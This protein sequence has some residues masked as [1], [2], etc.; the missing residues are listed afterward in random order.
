L[1]RVLVAS[2]SFG[3]G[4]PRKALEELLR[5]H[6]LNPVFSSIEQAGESI[7][8]CEGII[9]GTEQAGAALFDRSKALKAIIKYGVGIDNIDAR[10]AEQRGIKVLSLPEINSATV[11]EM[12][13]SLMLACARKIVEGNRALRNKNTDRPVG[14]PVR[15]KTLG[16]L[17]TGAIGMALV[18]MVSGLEMN[19]LAHDIKPNPEL[20]NLGGRYL[21]LEKLLED[22]DF[23]SIHLP[24]NEQTFHSIGSQE[25]SLMKPG[26]ILI[27]TSRGGVVDEEALYVALVEKKIGGAA[28][29]VFETKPPW[30]SKILSLKN[31]VCTPHIAAY[32]DET[33]RRM[34]AACMATLSRALEEERPVPEGGAVPMGTEG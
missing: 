7:G 32:T 13:L 34:D 2:H 33:L 30:K 28:L 25:L 14:V 12:A 11:A 16:L 3:R 23:L 15:G 17:G 8:E 1:H 10:A 6:G 31:V 27:N 26:A 29:D 9:I 20:V 22:S 18:R 21:P 4:A 19:V 5:Q 24:L